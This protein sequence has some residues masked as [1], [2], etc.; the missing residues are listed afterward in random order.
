M[1][2]PT[3]RTTPDA[4]LAATCS[5]PW[6]D[7]TCAVAF[8]TRPN[9]SALTSVVAKSMMLLCSLVNFTLLAGAS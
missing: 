6:L 5:S 2:F 4:R 7:T 8:I 1:S 9:F 3:N